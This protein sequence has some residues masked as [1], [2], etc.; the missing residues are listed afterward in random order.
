[1][2][3]QE[4]AQCYRFTGSIRCGLSVSVL[5]EID[6]A[7]FD[8]ITATIKKRLFDSVPKER[9]VKIEQV[10]FVVPRF[11]MQSACLKQM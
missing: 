9:Y 3:L 10:S 5:V 4:Q 1:M 6:P 8:T 7:E 2:A 11:L